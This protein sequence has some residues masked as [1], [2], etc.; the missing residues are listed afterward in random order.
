M[1]FVVNTATLP[2]VRGE[3][4]T[5]LCNPLWPEGIM[6]PLVQ[7]DLISNFVSAVL[8]LTKTTGV[9]VL[10]VPRH[11]RIFS[12]VALGELQPRKGVQRRPKMPNEEATASLLVQHLKSGC[13]EDLREWALW[14]V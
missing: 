7:R 2:L 6:L 3:D 11:H 1:H 4:Q 13:S 9:K 14:H 10:G 8:F 12:L 5:A